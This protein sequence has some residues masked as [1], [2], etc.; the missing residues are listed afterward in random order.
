M[1]LTLHRAFCQD[2]HSK[3]KI[4]N[5]L[6]S[7]QLQIQPLPKRYPIFPSLLHERRAVL[8]DVQAAQLLMAP[9]A[10]RDDAGGWAPRWG[11]SKNIAASSSSSHYSP[12]LLHR[13]WQC[14]ERERVLEVPG[15]RKGDDRREVILSTLGSS[16]P[17]PAVGLTLSLLF[18]Y[19]I[20]SSLAEPGQGTWSSVVVC[21]EYSVLFKRAALSPC[22]SCFCFK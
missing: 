12:P 2:K 13:K 22:L 21:N 7:S 5:E 19:V 17:L 4:C 10:A 11:G 15:R 8:M 3:S 1:I 16:Q 18:S 6:S 14:R 9:T 20:Y